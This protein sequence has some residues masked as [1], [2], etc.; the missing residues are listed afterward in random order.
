MS[1]RDYYEI[2]GISKNASDDEIKRAYK[3][4]A[5]EY[6][7]DV[8]KDK[9]LAEEKFKEINEAYQILSNPEKHRSYDQFG[10]ASTAQ[11]AGSARG[12]GAYGG[13]WGPFTYTYSSQGSNNGFDFG[14][15]F[16]PFDVFEQVF[17]S[18]GFGT[19]RE[20]RGKS[21]QYELGISFAESIHGCQKQIV[22]REKPLKIKIP[23][24]VASG[25]Q[26]KY[27]GEGEPAPQ[28]GIPGDLFIV[29]KVQTHTSI[30]RDESSNAYSLAQ[31]SYPQAVLGDNIEIESIDPNSPSGTKKIKLKIPAGTQHGTTFRIRGQ[32]FPNVRGSHRGDHFVQVALVV[33]SRIS[34]NQKRILEDLKKT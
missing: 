1:K 21:L 29:I 26:I 23:A 7:P 12:G 5:K 9:K 25:S 22:I 30:Q 28:G 10:H 34:Y 27:A 15:D 17:G 6:H 32:G 16:D 11:Q 19:R 18:R 4:L 8:A 33:P 13:S 31:I 20:K 3:K 24:G 14:G 2:L